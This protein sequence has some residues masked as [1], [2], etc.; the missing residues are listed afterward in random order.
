MES[1]LLNKLPL[2]VL[3]YELVQS[4]PEELELD[5]V[6]TDEVLQYCKSKTDEEAF[7]NGRD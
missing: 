2:P 3:F 6:V 4:E 7:Y 1:L 5:Q